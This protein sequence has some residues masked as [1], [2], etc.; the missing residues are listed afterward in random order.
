MSE[1]LS[2]RKAAELITSREKASV[3]GSSCGYGD[4]STFY[5]NFKKY[6]GMSPSEYA[7]TKDN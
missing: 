2:D 7:K 6:M 4:S 3:A 1:P 5:R